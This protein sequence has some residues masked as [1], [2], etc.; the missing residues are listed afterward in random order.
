[1]SFR[2]GNWTAYLCRHGETEMNHSDKLQGKHNNTTLD[3]NGLMQ[4][5]LLGQR[6]A[7]LLASARSVVIANSPLRRAQQTADAVAN[8]LST[9]GIPITRY[10]M[11]DFNE[12]EFGVENEGMPK[13]QAI[14][15]VHPTFEEWAHGHIDAA[16]YPDAENL[17][18]I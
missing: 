16:A 6:L 12:L 18:H 5:N 11:E 9:A 15:A 4:A 2:S 17:R 10:V 1:M 8:H 7:Q 3:R 14:A 13:A